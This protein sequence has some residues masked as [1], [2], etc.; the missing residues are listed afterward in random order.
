MVKF[1][2]KHISAQNITATSVDAGSYGDISANN[3]DLSSGGVNAP[4]GVETFASINVNSFGT[5]NLTEI[6][7]QTPGNIS[8]AGIVTAT[9][10]DTE[11]IFYLKMD[12]VT[13]HIH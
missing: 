2:C 7:L 8:G 10:F 11:T 9:E 12:L 13:E 1:D 5:L 6:N 3:L 4:A